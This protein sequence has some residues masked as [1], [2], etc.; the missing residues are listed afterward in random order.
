L[1]FVR[2]AAAWL[3][4]WRAAERAWIVAA[5][6]RRNLPRLAMFDSGNLR[7]LAMLDQ[8]RAKFARGEHAYVWKA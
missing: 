8:F 1:S 7:A 2:I 5:R 3:G 4:D 6:Y